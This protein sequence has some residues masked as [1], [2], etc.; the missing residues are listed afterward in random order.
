MS[1]ISNRHSVVPFVSGSSVPMSEQRLARVLY[2][3]SKK[4]AG[5]NIL[6]SVCTSVLFLSD[7]AVSEQIEQLLPHVKN[8]LESV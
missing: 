5:K 4:D 7:D 3:T 1:V 8:M 2:K 6:P